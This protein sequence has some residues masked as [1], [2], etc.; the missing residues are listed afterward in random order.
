M[1]FLKFS[2]ILYVSGQGSVLFESNALNIY[3]KL[4]LERH[5]CILSDGIMNIPKEQRNAFFP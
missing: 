3:N 4:N 1:S 5:L 2:V